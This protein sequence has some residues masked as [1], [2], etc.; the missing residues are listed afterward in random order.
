M[1]NI[2]KEKYNNLSGFIFLRLLLLF[3]T[4]LEKIMRYIYFLVEL[5]EKNSFI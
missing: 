4:Y 2:N 1:I 3:F 5:L